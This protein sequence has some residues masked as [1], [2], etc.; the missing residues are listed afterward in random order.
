MACNTGVC[1]RQGWTVVTKGREGDVES[2]E[3]FV[4]NDPLKTSSISLSSHC[5][6][7]LLEA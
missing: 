4:E 2:D 3:L 1:S 5:V 7:L 6:S